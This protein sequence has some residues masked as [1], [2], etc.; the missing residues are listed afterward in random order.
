MERIKS[1][2]KTVTAFSLY[3]MYS[4]CLLT[5]KS[6]L[7]CS[8]YFQTIGDIVWSQWQNPKRN[9]WKILYDIFCILPSSG[10]TLALAE[11][12]ARLYNHPQTDIRP[13]LRQISGLCSDRYPASAPKQMFVLAISQPFLN[14]LSWNFAWL[15]FRWKGWSLQTKHTLKY[16][17]IPCSAAKSLIEP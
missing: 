8:I 7:I 3:T 10:K 1:K 14:G 9:K 4:K 17:S 15:L 13:L 2:A 12:E 5:N 6:Y 16:C 11:P